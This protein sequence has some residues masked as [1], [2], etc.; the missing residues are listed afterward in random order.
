MPDLRVIFPKPCPEKWETM[1]PLGYNRSCAL[2]ENVIH[3]LTQYEVDEAEALL[4]DNP[5]ACVRAKIGPFGVVVMKATRSGNIRQVIATVGVSA[6]LL[7]S[8]PAISRERASKGAISGQNHRLDLGSRI[9][10]RNAEGRAF[11]A[12]VK[13]NGYYRIKNLVPGTYT[14]EFISSCGESW[15]NPNV[16]VD[17]GQTAISEPPRDYSECIVVGRL[18]IEEHRG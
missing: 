13:T 5:E 3:D 17:G 14:V 8:S 7:M 15:T 9:V 18:E 2:C 10:A 12:T 11:R 16:I 6:G 4:R 1:T